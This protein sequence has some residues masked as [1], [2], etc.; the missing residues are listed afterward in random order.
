[1]LEDAI[2]KRR[3]ERMLRFLT[4]NDSSCINT[5]NDSE[6]SSINM[7]RGRIIEIMLTKSEEALKTLNQTQYF[8]FLIRQRCK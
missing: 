7:S 2:E 4:Q 6:T 8:L 3:E 1:M 5:D